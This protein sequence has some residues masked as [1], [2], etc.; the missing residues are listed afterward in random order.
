[1]PKITFIFN[2]RAFFWSLQQIIKPHN[3]NLIEGVKNGH[4]V[5]A[6]FLRFSFKKV[7]G[8]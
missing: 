4:A 6:C 1:M 2:P 8:K 5:E 7:L 3:I